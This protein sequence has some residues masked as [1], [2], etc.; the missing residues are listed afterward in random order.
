MIKYRVWDKI[1]GCYVSAY[2]RACHNESYWDS[3]EA[4][5]SANCHD[6]FKDNRQYE[7]HKVEV[8]EK[9]ICTMIPSESVRKIT[10]QLRIDEEEKEAFMKEKG[11]QKFEMEHIM[12][13]CCWKAWK[14][15]S[16][17]KIEQKYYN[18]LL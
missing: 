14:K 7:I 10:E 16:L 13:F 4:A 6:T 11:I 8:T 2:F 1:N 9:T 12:P 18:S 17:E 3:Q 15:V 5:E